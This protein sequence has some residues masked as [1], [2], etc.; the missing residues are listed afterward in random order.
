MSCPVCGDRC[1][2]A[3]A[4]GRSVIAAPYLTEAGTISAL[5]EPDLNPTGMSYPPRETGW[6][7][8]AASLTT[9]SKNIFSE[10]M[11]S[12]DQ[13]LE[14]HEP[15]RD[16]VASRLNNYR[17]RQKRKV[18]PESSMR[19]DF[20]AQPSPVHA[21]IVQA[22]T[23][24]IPDPDVSC[25]V[26]Y[27][28]RTNQA[29][30][31]VYEP[32]QEPEVSDTEVEDAAMFF[33]S[34]SSEPKYDPDF[35]FE[36]P[37]MY[38]PAPPNPGTTDEQGNLIVF[39]T[40]PTYLAEPPVYELAEPV[41]ERPRILEVPEEV[42]PTI[43]GPLFANIDL[44]PEEQEEPVRLGPI[45]FDV[46][47]QVALIGQR[48]YGGVIDG[49]FVLCGF[50]VLS[51]VAWKIMPDLPNGKMALLAP[52]AILAILWLAYQYMFITYSGQT[53]GMQI[54]NMSLVNFE[55]GR[56]DF[57]RRRQRALS[58]IV[59][60]ISGGVGFGWALLDPDTLCWHDSISRT[61]VTQDN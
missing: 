33:E 27:F 3:Y 59:S 26:E 34:E 55:G 51:A 12:A 16:E 40:Q 53:P 2:C 24:R 31:P 42:M 28:R 15:W 7:D 5:I 13:E 48:L 23:E 57:E 8:S 56:P 21:A 47:L 11:P 58:M 32:E 52:F 49:L 61:Y 19:L 41:M 20:D 14:P 39:P 25:D 50:G 38:V 22:V 35:D 45:H 10:P 4:S 37:R 30:A 9:S 17:R 6:E 60:L 1:S 36:R 18:D 29:T 43:Q 44:D 54:A 46:P